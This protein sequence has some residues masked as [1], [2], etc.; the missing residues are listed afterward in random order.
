MLI[1]GE[2]FAAQNWF[3]PYFR[4]G[5]PIYIQRADLPTGLE[6]APETL[7]QRLKARPHTPRIHFK[8]IAPGWVAFREAYLESGNGIRYLPV[9]HSVAQFDRDQGQVVVT[10]Y[11]NWYVM[12]TLVYM[13]LRALAEPSFSIV[14]ALILVL[15]GLSYAAQWGINRAVVEALGNRPEA[16]A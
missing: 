3:G 12:F 14:A 5:L 16:A 1:A 6:T 13:L 11:L 2:F 7:E 15:F 8:T 10:G 9:M 4:F